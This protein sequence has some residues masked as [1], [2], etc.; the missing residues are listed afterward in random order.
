MDKKNGTLDLK[1]VDKYC[2]S[3]NPMYDCMLLKATYTFKDLGA[4]AIG[5]LEEFANVE[6]GKI[7]RWLIVPDCM[8]L[9]SLSIAVAHS[10]GLEAP[11]YYSSC[12]ME[13]NEQKEI[14]PSLEDALKQCGSIFDNPFDDDYHEKMCSAISLSEKY[15]PP[16]TYSML[17]SPSI[18]YEEAQNKI[19]EE[20]KDV[21]KNGIKINGK[22]HML[23]S[24]PGSPF[25]L[26]GKTKDK[27]FD[28]SDEMCKFIE[29]KDVL[30]KEGRQ[31]YDISKRFKGYRG[32]NT[33][34]KRKGQPFC[35]R[36]LVNT[37]FGED[38]AFSITLERPK[39]IKSLIADGYLTLE[40]YLESL[41]YVSRSLN[42]DCI[43]KK[44]YNLFAYDEE[45]YYAF[46]I[47]IH[48]G[49]QNDIVKEASSCGWTEPTMDLK[50][51]FR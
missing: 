4:A 31:R 20:I 36:I 1:L 27:D 8:T 50:K 30:I 41:S 6:D 18:S 23:S 28:W 3:M 39:S 47:M 42:P 29:V 34:G 13:E 25:I 37:Y 5:D 40:N 49:I 19:E 21:K 45:S 35:K 48:S 7:E 14:F 10:F 12:M 38:L 11:A 46:I 44:G 2:L 43:C 15:I 17:L 24:L 51:I 16:L 26:N 33:F 32:L 22:K 9:G